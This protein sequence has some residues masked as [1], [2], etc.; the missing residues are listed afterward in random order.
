MTLGHGVTPL[1]DTSDTNVPLRDMSLGTG[2]FPDPSQ[3]QAPPVTAVT[4]RNTLPGLGRGFGEGGGG[5]E[6]FFTIYISSA[7]FL[8]LSF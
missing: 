8:Q 3:G 4:P 6:C 2:V 5:R 1:T 7:S